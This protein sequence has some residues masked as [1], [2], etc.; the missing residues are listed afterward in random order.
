VPDLEFKCSGNIFTA[1]P[2]AGRGFNR[3]Q[4]NNSRNGKGDPPEDVV[5]FLVILHERAIFLER[6]RGKST[7]IFL[8]LHREIGDA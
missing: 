3:K 7:K 1:I 5:Q 6:M 8:N 4:V 2:P